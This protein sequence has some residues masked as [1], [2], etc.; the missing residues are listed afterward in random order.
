[1]GE[2]DCAAA[3]LTKGAGVTRF[4]SYLIEAQKKEREQLL[5]ETEVQ[6]RQSESLGR[7]AN[8]ERPGLRPLVCNREHGSGKKR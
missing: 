7:K 5:S 3:N 6:R 2:P 1:M 8:Q 4:M